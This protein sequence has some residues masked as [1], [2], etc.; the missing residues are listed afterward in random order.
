MSATASLKALFAIA[1][2]WFALSLGT[3]LL[4]VFAGEGIRPALLVILYVFLPLC[5]FGV[6]YANSAP[7][8][9]T[10]L[11]LD[12]RLVVLVQ[13]LRVIGG[14]FLVYYAYGL[15]PGLFAFPAGLGDVAIGATAP[16]VAAVVLSK[17]PF[18][19]RA[20]VL[21]NLLGI[22]DLVCAVSLGILTSSSSLGL[23]ASG[24]TIQPLLSFPLGLIPA[25]GVPL[26]LV[27]HVV[28]LLQAQR[29]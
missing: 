19:R 16:F 29:K 14:V 8:R 9:G 6:V 18:P 25:Y 4:G 26:T 23:L 22:L 10:V 5:L 2:L 20:F 1:I 24:I 21:W 15:L 28:A 11:S 3:V 7:F 12:M 17:Q 27:L 13:T